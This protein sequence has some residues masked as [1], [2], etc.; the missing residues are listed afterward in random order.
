[1]LIG[2]D[3]CY[4]RI[5]RDDPT[6]WY[7]PLRLEARL[8][9][10]GKVQFFGWSDV[11]TISAGATEREIFERFA[12]GRAGSVTFQLSDQGAI[13]LRRDPHGH[14]DVVFSL[15]YERVGPHWKLGGDVHIEGEQT[16]EFLRQFRDLVFGSY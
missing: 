4:L 3:D 15:G 8:R 14:I 7:A 6:D 12:E 2:S 1:M 5:E 16:V 10:P 11:A 9:M 13:E